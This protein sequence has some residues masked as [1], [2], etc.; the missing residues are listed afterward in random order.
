MKQ[1]SVIYGFLEHDISFRKRRYTLR[2]ESETVICYIRVSR[3]RKYIQQRRCVT[4]PKV[5]PSSTYDFLGHVFLFGRGVTFRFESETVICYLRVSQV[6]S[7]RFLALGDGD[8]GGGDGVSP[9]DERRRLVR[10]NIAEG[11]VLSKQT[12]IRGEASGRGVLSA[13]WNHFIPWSKLV[14]QSTQPNQN[15]PSRGQSHEL[16]S[17]AVKRTVLHYRDASPRTTRTVVYC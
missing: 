9:V 3:A 16:T 5:K 8:G 14:F 15:Q 6:E 12:S 7:H 1:L 4:V 10:K 2:F 17:V 13:S 11:R